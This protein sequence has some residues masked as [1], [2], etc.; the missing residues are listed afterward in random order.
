MNYLNSAFATDSA[1]IHEKQRLVLILFTRDYQQSSLYKNFQTAQIPL[2]NYA[3]FYVVN[4]AE[5]PDFTHLYELSRD[6]IMFF[7]K[8]RPVKSRYGFKVTRPLESSDFEHEI[9]STYLSCKRREKQKQ[10]KVT[11]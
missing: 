6:A 8:K 1:I 2:R 4:L 7:Y 3:I 11:F 10:Q 9:I 5:V